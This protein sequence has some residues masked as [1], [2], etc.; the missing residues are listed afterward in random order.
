MTHS[1]FRQRLGALAEVAS[2]V[3]L[4]EIGDR[5]MLATV[6]L[7]A[8]APRPLAAVVS[9]AA[10][11]AASMAAAVGFGALAGRHVSERAVEAASGVLCLLCAAASVL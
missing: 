1:V 11:H 10:G 9:A 5:S 7:G 4:A 6:A 2:L 3:F 8:T